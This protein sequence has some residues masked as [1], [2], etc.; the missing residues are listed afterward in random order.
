MAW[1][2]GT[3]FLRLLF[4]LLLAYLIFLFLHAL[5]S[6]RK[7]RGNLKR[8]TAHPEE[9]MVFDPQCKSYIPKSDALIRRGEYFCSEECARAFLSR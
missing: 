5:L 6:G 4:F 1:K 2:G 7:R 8:D 3:L 9:E